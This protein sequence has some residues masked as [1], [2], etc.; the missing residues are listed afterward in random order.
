MCFNIHLSS[1]SNKLLHIERSS[2]LGFKA[3]SIAYKLFIMFSNVLSRTAGV[4]PLIVFKDFAFM[5][6]PWSYA[7][8]CYIVVI[9]LQ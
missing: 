7:P 1:Y 2:V 3:L 4:M 6:M 9:T 8:N 5:P